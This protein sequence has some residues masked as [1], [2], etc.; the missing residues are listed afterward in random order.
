MTMPATKSPLGVC[1]SENRRASKPLMEKRRRARINKS[2]TELKSLIL[3][4]A[5]KEPQTGRHSKL[6]KADILELTVKHLQTL[7]KQQTSTSYSTDPLSMGKFRAGYAECVKE[8][9]RFVTRLEGVDSVLR[10][11]LL[12][13]MSGCLAN[14]DD[15]PSINTSDEKTPSGDDKVPR[16]MT[17][18]TLPDSSTSNTSVEVDIFHGVAIPPSIRTSSPRAQNTDLIHFPAT[19]SSA[20]KEFSSNVTNV[21]LA[22]IVPESS[23]PTRSLA[24]LYPNGPLNLVT[25]NKTDSQLS[26]YTT[27]SS[28]VSIRSTP[29][30]PMSNISSKGYSSDSEASLGNGSLASPKMSSLSAESV[31]HVARVGG[32][33]ACSVIQMAPKSPEVVWRPW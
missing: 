22:L 1:K 19:S 33:S 21:Q 27:M 23:I 24:Q 20:T 9:S 32:G 14:F 15:T 16:A 3:D 17:P 25:S 18:E 28:T 26:V 30:T 10:S 29:S 2:L 11:R 4:A 6:E 5:K 31:Y 8:V 12:N 13:H 7:H